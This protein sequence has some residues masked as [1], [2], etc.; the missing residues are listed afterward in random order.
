MASI[1]FF[2]V[3]HFLGKAHRQFSGMTQPSVLSPHEMMAKKHA[4]PAGLDLRWPQ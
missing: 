1:R 4:D 2:I 3:A